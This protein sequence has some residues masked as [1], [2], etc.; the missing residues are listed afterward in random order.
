MLVGFRNVEAVFDQ[1]SVGLPHELV[2]GRLFEG[3]APDI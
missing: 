2:E 3:A 1:E